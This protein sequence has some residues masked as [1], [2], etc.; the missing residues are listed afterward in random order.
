MAR[1]I[2]ETVDAYSS[3]IDFYVK[4]DFDF[5]TNKDVKDDTRLMYFDLKPFKDKQQANIN[6]KATMQN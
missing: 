3:A 1:P 4:N 6:P 5:F 2:K